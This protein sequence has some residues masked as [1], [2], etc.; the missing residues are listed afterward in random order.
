MKG[1]L[2]AYHMDNKTIPMSDISLEKGESVFVEKNDSLY[3]AQGEIVE[4]TKSSLEFFAPKFENGGYMTFKPGE[5]IKISYWSSA[6]NR[7]SFQAVVQN[8]KSLT[9]TYSIGLPA[10]VVHD[11]VRR[12]TRYK[13]INMLVSFIHK[14]SNAKV[15][16]TVYIARV[17]NISAGGLL[18]TTPKRFNVGDIIAVGFYVGKTF[19]TGVCEVK[20]NSASKMNLGEFDVAMQILNYSDKDK[21]FLETQLSTY[22]R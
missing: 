8:S 3:S 11:G 18:I 13:P 21:T 17:V 20:V 6:G 12:W 22:I 7:Y 10:N 9:G 15:N 14:A 5:K 2:T 4:V 19:F 1:G 16:D